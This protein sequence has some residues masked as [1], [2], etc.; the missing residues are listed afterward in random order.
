MS[1]IILT[2]EEAEKI[3]FEIA[4]GYFSIFYNL[5]D[6]QKSKI[7][8]L[9]ISNASNALPIINKKIGFNFHIE[10]DECWAIT[11]NDVDEELKKNPERWDEFSEF[12]F[13]QRLAD[14]MYESQETDENTQSA[15]SKTKPEMPN[16][17]SNFSKINQVENTDTF[18]YLKETAKEYIALYPQRL[19]NFLFE[20]EADENDFIEKEL[21]YFES[22]MYDLENSE[23]S[24]NGYSISGYNNFNVA[25]NLVM[26]IGFEKFKYSTQ[27]KI[28]FLNQNKLIPQIQNKT[29]TN[30]EQPKT[31]E[32]L[33]YNPDHAEPC[34]KIL[35]E[36]DPPAIDSINNYIGKAKGI[37]PLWIKVLKNHKPYPLIKHFKD[38]VYKDLLNQKVKGLNLTKDA[39]EFRKQYRRIE[40]DK[41]ELDIKTLLSQYSQS[42]KL[43]K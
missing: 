19:K 2:D 33:F 31:F 15:E 40:T 27:K 24:H 11:K 16:F 17:S 41:I 35:N 25:Y 7:L 32:E 43:G 30:I 26:E 6:Y 4:N 13:W 22:T 37:F 3:L 29:E 1:N 12:R 8:N 42:G 14:R 10:T 21:K 9:T 38:T 18:K 39:S 34:L 5:N 36:L 28:K 20:F 23:N